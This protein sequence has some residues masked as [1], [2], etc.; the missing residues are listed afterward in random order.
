MG[1]HGPISC[2]IPD[3][4]HASAE[5]TVD[6]LRV[7]VAHLP[8]EVTGWCGLAVDFDYVSESGDREP[9][10]RASR[11]WRTGLSITEAS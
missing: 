3:H 2:G 11:S 7:V 10:A 4:D 8:R 5:L 9:P 6:L 1:A